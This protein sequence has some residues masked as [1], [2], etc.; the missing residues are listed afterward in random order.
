MTKQGFTMDIPSR[1]SQVSG[2]DARWGVNAGS[3]LALRDALWD[4]LTDSLSNTPM[5][6]TPDETKATCVDSAQ[7]RHLYLLI[8]LLY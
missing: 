4:G 5:G 8:H 1:A 7:D 6:M 3:G 2:N